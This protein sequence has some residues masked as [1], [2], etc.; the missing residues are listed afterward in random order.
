MVQRLRWL[1][2]RLK[3]QSHS[4]FPWFWASRHIFI[5]SNSVIY[6]CLAQRSPLASRDWKQLRTKPDEVSSGRWNNGQSKVL[7]P[8]GA[9]PFKAKASTKHDYMIPYVC[10][11]VETAI[12]PLREV[13]V[14]LVV[15]LN[16]TQAV[17]SELQSVMQLAVELICDLVSKKS[18]VIAPTSEG[19]SQH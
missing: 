17:K 16:Q 5:A 1:W 7:Y 6:F 10:T 13:R 8:N 18:L 19:W 15:S 2:K 11:S 14:G 3:A 9:E 4:T 12:S